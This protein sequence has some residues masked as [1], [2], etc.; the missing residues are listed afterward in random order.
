VVQFYAVA[1][2]PLEKITPSIQWRGGWV[3]GPQN[4]CGHGGEEK[5]LY[6][7]WDLNPISLIAEL[8]A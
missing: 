6:L 3:G 7:C 4:Y 8:I 5:N 2:L 1:N